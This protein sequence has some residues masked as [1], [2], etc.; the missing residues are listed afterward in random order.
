MAPKKYSWKFLFLGCLRNQFPLPEPKVHVSHRITSQRLSLTDLSN[1]G[2][3]LSVSDLSS[4]I[5]N[6]H[7]FTLKELKTATQNLSK[8]NYLGEGGFGAVYKGFITDKLRP[9]LKAQSVAVKALDLDGSQ[10]HREWLAEVIFL[11][12]LKHP[13]LVNLIGYCCEDEH[14]LLVYEYM[15]RGNLENLLFKRYSAALPWLTRLKIALGA[16]KG[17]AFL[18][19]EEK[20]VIYRDFKASNVLLDADFNA[21]LSDF[22]LATDGPQG[23]ESHIS[24]RVMGT[25]GYA[26]PEYIM[27]GHLTAMSDVFS[28]GVV[29]LELLTGRRSVDKNRP[30]REQNLVKWAR[31][32]LKDHHKLDLI[33]DPRLEGQ[34]STEGARK[35]AALAYQC[36]SHHCKS[37]PSMTS[38]VKTLE[39]L[40]ELND[41]P[42]GTFVYIVPSEGKKE[43]DEQEKE[44]QS[45]IECKIE[46]EDGKNCE[47]KPLDMKEKSRHRY[48]KGRRHRRRIKSL[49]S[50]AVHSDT[51]LYKT[52]GTSLYSPE[53]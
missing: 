25:E 21:K 50:R 15:E 49:R 33:M 36:L 41:I 19:E 12:Q 42:M 9:G 11:G 39:S 31:P 4:S 27:T 40:L 26:A 16:A 2:S 20:P 23:D 52:L 53:Q 6:L 46:N 13:H 18:H 3:P 14:R 5:F 43:I 47:V 51:A 32:L 8:S 30:S 38:V 45:E 22:G 7:V 48:Q 29:L 17:L 35:A 34:Y 24:T 28:F 44:K 10:G 37:R 1:P